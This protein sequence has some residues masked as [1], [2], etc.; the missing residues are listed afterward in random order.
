MSE[1]SKSEN[2]IYSLR[3]EKEEN[4]KSSNL[5]SFTTSFKNSTNINL[6]HQNHSNIE[7][8]TKTDISVSVRGRILGIRSFGKLT[9]IDLSD[10]TG[11]IQLVSTKGLLSEELQEYLSNSNEV[12]LMK[13]FDDFFT[14]APKTCELYNEQKNGVEVANVEEEINSV[15]KN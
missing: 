7:D 3:K 11:K 2:E 15:K 12:G 1:L 13:E 5:E 14:R 10:E 4:I 9:F 8:G 6:L